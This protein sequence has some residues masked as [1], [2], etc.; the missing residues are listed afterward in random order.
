MRSVEIMTNPN[1]AT[2][3]GLG[4]TGDWPEGM[5]ASL[6]SFAR[7]LATTAAELSS[8]G[9]TLSREAG[10]G[11]QESAER[12]R[13]TGADAAV[14]AGAES[15]EQFIES[16]RAEIQQAVAEAAQVRE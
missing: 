2:D 13:G 11:L 12:R 14:E 9:E 8:A 15:Y 1:P 5:A 6:Q 16:S 7:R 10:G 3:D 4:A